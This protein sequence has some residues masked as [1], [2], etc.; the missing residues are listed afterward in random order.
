MDFS[1]KLISN[2]IKWTACCRTGI[3]YSQLKLIKILLQK[4]PLSLFMA[5]VFH[6]F[7]F[8]SYFCELPRGYR[9]CMDY[10]MVHVSNSD[11]KGG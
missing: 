2:S 11:L 5:C 9:Q 1:D 4:L 3:I 8:V 10:C 7:L 6:Y